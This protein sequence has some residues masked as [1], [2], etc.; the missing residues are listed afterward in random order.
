[1]IRR[2]MA[3]TALV[4]LI[5]AGAWN[6]QAQTDQN[7]QQ[8]AATEQPVTVP[9]QT[10][11]VP[12]DNAATTEMAAGEA[13]ATLT[14]EQPTLATAFMG[15]AVYSSEDPESDKIGDVNDLIIGENGEITHAVVGVGGFLG[16]GEKDV[17]VP[18]KELKVVEREGDIRLIYSATKEQLEAAEALDRTAY[19]PRARFQEEQAAN[20]P[21]ATEQPAVDQ[22]QET[23][24][25]TEQPA[26]TEQPAVDQTAQSTDQQATDQMAASTEQPAADQ[27]QE[28]TAATE[29]P[30]A[31]QSQQATAT[32]QTEVAETGDQ[33][34]QD[35]EQQMAAAEPQT[36]DQKEQLA[37]GTEL[38]QN[39]QT[40]ETSTDGQAAP[41]ESSFLSFNA[42]QV[43]ASALMG[44][45]LYGADD[46]SIGEVADLVLQEDGKTRAAIVDVGG[47]LGVGEKRVA[48]P[49]DQIQ[50]TAQDN[51]EPKLTVAMTKEQLEQA[52]AWQD[53]TMGSEQAAADQNATT[54]D[55][56]TN[57][58][59]ADQNATTD[60]QTTTMAADQNAATDKQGLQIAT[61]DISADKLIGTKVYSPNDENVGEV[62]DV[63]F[64]KSGQID[65]VIIDV[66]GFL[67]VG[68]KPVAV[69]FDTL[70]VQRDDKGDVKLMINAS[71]D[72]LKNAPAYE[73]KAAQ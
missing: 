52:P 44:K 58:M 55:Q 22:S 67:G 53:R 37:T 19:D 66:G 33:Q 63:L 11:T 6:A 12:E 7:T 46:Q 1:M 39:Q 49:F 65:A 27:S 54:T 70:N 47:F 26:T 45:E 40:A 23:T 50:I 51:N 38:N 59:A 10:Q 68:E 25:A 2:L 32:D 30:A 8:P 71:A 64:D 14:P 61:Q 42:D 17:A 20:Q 13:H 15:K 31:D 48:I 60:Q 62:G 24:A 9:E 4:A 21:A 3:S 69:Q 29:Q 56:Q 57:T 35:Q 28:T 43:R 41:A 72:Q 73:V 18:F 36:A 34:A 5:T 16:I